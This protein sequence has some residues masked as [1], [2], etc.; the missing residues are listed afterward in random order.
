MIAF[1]MAGKATRDALFLSTYGA[2][3][4]PAMVMA[5]SAASLILAGLASRIG[6]RLDPTRITPRAFLFSAGLSMGEWFLVGSY[7]GPVAIFMYLHF[8]GLGALLVSGFWSVASERFDP[9][10]AKRLIA[11]IGA[12]GTIG[13]LLGGILAERGAALLSV[14]AMFPLL[15]TLHLAAALFTWK[16]GSGEAYPAVTAELDSRRGRPASGLEVLRRSPYLRSIGLLVIFAAVSEGLLDLSFKTWASGS[17]TQG[18]TLLRFF[19]IFYTVVALITMLVQTMATRG[20]LQR[21]GLAGSVGALPGVV[22]L[23]AGGVLLAPGLIPIMLARGAE[24]MVK[25]SL[26]RSGYE[27]LFNPVS[28]PDRRTIKPVLDV[29]FV[30]TGDLAAGALA[31]LVIMASPI[32]ALGAPVLVLTFL[33]AVAAMY[34]ARR[35]HRGYFKTLERS[36]LVRGSYL[37]GEGMSEAAQT[38]LF[39]T[40]GSIDLTQFQQRTT[41]D[42]AE[43]EPPRVPASLDADLARILELRSRDPSRVR[44]ALTDEPLPLHLVPHVVALLA[45]DEVARD[46][47]HALRPMA[48][49]ASGVLTDFLLD[50]TSEFAVRRRLPLVFADCS[51]QRVV[52]GL[53]EGLED[54]R[55]EVRYRCG[56]VLSRIH[57]DNPRLLMDRDR[58]LQAIDR[59]VAVDRAVWESRR[60]MDAMEE[61]VE[62]PVMDEALR[63]R[64]DRSLEHVFTMLSLILPRQPLRV[65]FRG[66]FTDD[67]M[68]RGTAL[69]YLE[70]ALPQDLRRKLWPFLENPGRRGRTHS[71]DDLMADLLKTGESIADRLEALK[72]LRDKPD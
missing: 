19:A 33:F 2:V 64:A 26:F 38:A 49:R 13:G 59:E 27:L 67:A 17:I 31:Q 15:A 36:L 70:S 8:T 58:V 48:H 39:Q 16:M 44:A 12:G 52:D 62:S 6:A 50:P 61:D 43:A 21:L 54:R 71:G 45:W 60:L 47:I 51:S 23:G 1:Q 56:R 24:S 53:L 32:G 14:E 29:G 72:R 69:E 28:A 18:T 65:A 7:R 37:E 20:L 63:D 55:F 30:R 25:N 42:E 57:A 68:L 22:A 66:L 4:L 41:I 9:R 46:A 10:T 5:A 3:K 35:L 34:V 40:L 11:R